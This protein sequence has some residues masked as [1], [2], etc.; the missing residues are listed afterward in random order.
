M[1]SKKVKND[2][3]EKKFSLK[4]I[5]RRTSTHYRELIKRYFECENE[6]CDWIINLWKY[7]KDMEYD[8]TI[9]IYAL[10]NLELIKDHWDDEKYISSEFLIDHLLRNDPSFFNFEVFIQAKDLSINKTKIY[11]IITKSC[12]GKQTQPVPT[13]LK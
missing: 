10:V 7:A 12:T 1:V 6:H 3:F 8:E 9:D 5:K 2:D 13:T 4:R 11:D